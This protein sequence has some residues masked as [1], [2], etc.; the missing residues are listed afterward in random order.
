M[1]STLLIAG[2]LAVLQES[3]VIRTYLSF[4]V[5]Q[6]GVVGPPG[7]NG[8]PGA[9]GLLVSIFSLERLSPSKRILSNI[10]V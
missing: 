10:F 4:F 7:E 9:I 1:D 3:N 8:A 2:S 5:F 6:Q